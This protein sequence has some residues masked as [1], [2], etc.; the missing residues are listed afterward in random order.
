MAAQGLA[1]RSRGGGFVPLEFEPGF[2]SK[3]AIV[4]LLPMV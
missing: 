3:F 2:D 1:W 4:P